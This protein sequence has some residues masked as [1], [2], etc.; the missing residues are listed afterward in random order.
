M[1]ASV[2]NIGGPTSQNTWAA[3]RSPMWKGTGFRGLVIPNN[4]NWSREGVYVPSLTRFSSG[5]PEAVG[6]MLRAF[7][8]LKVGTAGVLAVSTSMSLGCDFLIIQEDPVIVRFYLNLG[9]G[10][11]RPNEKDEKVK[12]GY[13]SGFFPFIPGR[14]G[15]DINSA[16][17]TFTGASV[18][19]T[20][21]P[22]PD[23]A[24]VTV[25]VPI[26]DALFKDNPEFVSGVNGI[27]IGEYTWP[28]PNSG[29]WP[30]P[31]W[32]INSV[33]LA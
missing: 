15:Y 31:R 28:E 26:N 20:L 23:M 3:V 8:F 25:S 9:L 2:V 22:G 1:P 19:V 29:D 11:G 24:P 17:A 18:S 32:T 27:T 6:P 10:E 33:T 13:G 4:K 14:M 16:R 21:N 5:Y 30:A 7:P 12:Q